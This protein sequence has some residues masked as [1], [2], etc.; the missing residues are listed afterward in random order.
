MIDEESIIKNHEYKVLPMIETLSGREI[1]K[2]IF[3]KKMKV[4]KKI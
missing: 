2:Q 3:T 1:R 4:N